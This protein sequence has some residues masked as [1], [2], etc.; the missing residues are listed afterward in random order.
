MHFMSLLL[1]L[2][3]CFQLFM[4]QSQTVV[5]NQEQELQSDA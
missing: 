4:L 2:C 1:Q 3:V 5:K